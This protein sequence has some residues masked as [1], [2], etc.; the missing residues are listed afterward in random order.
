MPAGETFLSKEQNESYRDEAEDRK[1]N[2]FIILIP[3]WMVSNGL[4]EPQKQKDGYQ[5]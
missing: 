4:R 5:Q 3:E 2:H 1:M